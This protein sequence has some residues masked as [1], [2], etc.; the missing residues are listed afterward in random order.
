MGGAQARGGNPEWRPLAWTDEQLLAVD[1]LLD[2]S[3]V[4]VL[5]ALHAVEPCQSGGG[6]QEA[7]AGQAD[8]TRPLLPAA[9]DRPA[10]Q[11]ALPTAA[12]TL[13]EAAAAEQQ[14]EEARQQHQQ[15]DTHQHTHQDQQQQAE[16]SPLASKQQAEQPR[17]L[18]QRGEAPVA[19]GDAVKRASGGDNDQQQRGSMQDVQQQ[20]ADVKAKRVAA[21]TDSLPANGDA[22]A[23]EGAP[24][25]SASE[26]P[27]AA[28]DAD[29]AAAAAA[30]LAALEPAAAP[31]AAPSAAAE[32]ASEEGSGSCV[33]A[34]LAGTGCCPGR[35]VAAW[36]LGSLEA[37]FPAGAWFDMM[38]AFVMDAGEPHA[39]APDHTCRH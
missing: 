27:D 4:Q 1:P 20:A 29:G 19:N 35:L 36:Q 30:A 15:T 2:G 11:L 5:L 9:A 16:Q 32:A 33:A 23:A 3:D 13:A 39:C 37:L 24:L 34:A 21:G 26:G 28:A 14:A 7:A 25:R 38:L 12:S 10:F 31:S 22:A 6:S 17:P 8:P 18:E